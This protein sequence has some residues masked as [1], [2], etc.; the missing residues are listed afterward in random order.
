M[1]KAKRKREYSKILA[2]VVII[3]GFVVVQECFIMMVYLVRN[4]YTSTAAWLTAAVGLGEAVIG[5]GA[6]NYF[7]LAKAQ[8]TEGGVTFESA[9]AKGFK[10]ED[11][12]DSP[13]I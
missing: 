6:T 5:V 9:K 12:I 7:S 10:H 4:S 13:P 8:N 3:F 11:S 1:T 2:M